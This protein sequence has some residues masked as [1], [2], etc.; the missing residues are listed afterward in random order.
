MSCWHEEF[1]RRKLHVMR[2]ALPKLQQVKFAIGG[3]SRL[4]SLGHSAK[5]K[6]PVKPY[7]ELGL[8]NTD[9]GDMYIEQLA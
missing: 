1:A 8:Q 2:I 7:A 9:N 4:Y 6:R 5:V 3:R